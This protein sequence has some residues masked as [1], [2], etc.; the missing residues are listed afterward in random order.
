M[1]AE[2]QARFTLRS[3]TR[4][5]RKRGSISA[6]QPWLRSGDGRE[7]GAEKAFRD[8]G[9]YLSGDK[10]EPSGELENLFGAVERA[11]EVTAE[12][13][14]ATSGAKRLRRRARSSTCRKTLKGNKAQGSNG[15]DV[16]SNGGNSQRTYQWSKALKT[17]FTGET[18]QQAKPGNGVGEESRGAW[19]VQARSTAVEASERFGASGWTQQPDVGMSGR[20]RPLVNIG[21]RDFGFWCRW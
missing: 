17:A 19:R 10:S 15:R 7:P 12:R 3:E 5:G 9:P 21:S 14:A 8:S 20:Q 6:P 11:V 4:A 2:S 13:A 16:A 18:R 1:R